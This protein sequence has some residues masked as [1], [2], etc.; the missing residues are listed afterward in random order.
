[1]QKNL[2]IAGLLAVLIIGLYILVPFR[3]Q[4]DK[5]PVISEESGRFLKGD[6]AIDMSDNDLAAVSARRKKNGS[7]Q[8][9]TTTV[10]A[11]TVTTSVFAD[12]FSVA[13]KIEETGSQSESVSKNWWVNSGAWLQSGNNLGS[14]VLGDLPTTDRWYK[15]YAATNTVDTDSGLHPQNIFR[16]VQR[17]QWANL[18]QQAYFKIQKINLSQSPNR[19]ASNGLFLFN[20][21]QTGDNLYYTGLRVDGAAVIKKKINGTYYTMAYKPFLSGSAYDRDKNP[22]LLPTGTWIGLKSVITTEVNNAVSI[23]FYVDVNRTGNWVLAVESTDD[24]K[25]FGGASITNPGFA[26]IRT[27][28]LDVLFN[29]YRI[30]EAQK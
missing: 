23:K 1:M 27:D 15:E 3:S 19:N 12:S 22:N 9:V 7:S 8:T 4:E 17:G 18:T 29:D 16:L 11:S 2:Q 21:Y 14:T 28:F 30:E 5:S 25:Q 10:P 20:R 6:V 26:G 24:A 13:Q